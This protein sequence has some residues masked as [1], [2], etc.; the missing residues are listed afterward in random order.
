MKNSLKMFYLELTSVLIILMLIPVFSLV[1]FQQNDEWVYYKNILNILSGSFTLHEKTAPTFLTIGL[2]ASFWSILFGIKAIPFLTLLISVANFYIFAKIIDLKFKFSKIMTIF[3]SGILFTNFLHSYSMIGFMTENYLI[4]FL[5]LSIYYFEKYEITSDKKFIHL[6]NLF[7]ILTFFVKQ[8]GII[9]LTATAC[10]YLIKKEYKKLK[11]Q[12]IYLFSVVTVYLI[13]FPKTSEMDKKGFNFDNL[14]EPFY[15]YSLIVGILLYLSFFT[16]PL[17]F[18]SIKKF[19]FLNHKSL[20]I[21]FL[22]LVSTI[23]IFF[24]SYKFFKPEFLA[25]QEFPYFQN[26]IERTGFLPRTLNGTKYQFKYNFVYWKY[27]D[28]ISKIA[29]SV[30]LVFILFN[31]RKIMNVYLISIFGFLT[32]MVFVSPFFDRYILYALPLVVILFCYF[33]KDSIFSKITVVLFVLYQSYFSYFWSLDYIYSH[34]YVWNKSIEI[35]KYHDPYDM[36]SSGAWTNT[37]GRNRVNPKYIFTY[38][39][40]TKNPDLLQSYNVID[41]RKIDFYGNL[42]INPEIYLYQIK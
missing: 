38:D 42:F 5:L 4:F 41:V 6:S 28:L 25:W 17:I 33:I 27:S 15:I 29:L 39:S 22:F 21:L 13:L 26:V 23:L 30:S 20:K 2:M 8:T 19:I 32:L 7:S 24:L 9:F 1:N 14:S 31:F 36:L 18:I 3:V 40:P 10:Y 12:L 16:L 34:N 37:Y 11:I 35:S